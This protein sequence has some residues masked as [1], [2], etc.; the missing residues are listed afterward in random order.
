MLDGGLRDRGLGRRRATDFGWMDMAQHSASKHRLDSVQLGDLPGVGTIMVDGTV[1][2]HRCRNTQ[3]AT[4]YRWWRCS[5]GDKKLDW[6]ALVSDCGKV[7]C[8]SIRGRRQAL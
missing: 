4:R 8:R 2:R 3:P 7:G 6:V 5:A 1:R